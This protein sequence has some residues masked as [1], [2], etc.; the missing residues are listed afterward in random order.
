MSMLQYVASSLDEQTP[1]SCLQARRVLGGAPRNPA[2]RSHFLAWID[3][4]S[5]CH[6]KDVF[7]GN[8]YCGVPTLSGVLP[9]SLTKGKVK[10]EK[11]ERNRV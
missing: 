11:A 6:S 1:R 2:P 8:K 9:L 5:G 3:K 4:P 7:A 10:G